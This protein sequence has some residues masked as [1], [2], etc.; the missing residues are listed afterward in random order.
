LEVEPAVARKVALQRR[1]LE[2]MDLRFATA[3]LPA[4]VDVR[5]PA[6]LPTPA[7]TN[8]SGLGLRAT[9][10]CATIDIHGFARVGR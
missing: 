6:R 3:I 7:A 4:Q 2:I 9:V 5:H 1:D 8:E 10:Q